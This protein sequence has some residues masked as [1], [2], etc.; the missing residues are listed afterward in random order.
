MEKLQFDDGLKEFKVNGGRVIRFAPNDPEF[1]EQLYNTMQACETIHKAA[2]DEESVFTALREK[3][4]AI[5][6]EIDKL[7]GDGAAADIF[8]R[9]TL[10][11]VNGAPRWLNFGY[12]IIDAII[13]DIDANIAQASPRMQS[14]M[15]KLSKYKRK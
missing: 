15:A 4:A 3:D 1:I 2:V 10:G 7:F 6:M 5:R 14:Y 12:A 13:A 9:S 11:I 8:P